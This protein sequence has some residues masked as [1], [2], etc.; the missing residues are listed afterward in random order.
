MK[1]EILIPL[2]IL[3]KA[4]EELEKELYS[5]NLKRQNKQIRL[6]LKTHKHQQ[7]IGNAYD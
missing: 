3:A 4:T 7:A 2:A 1:K 6:A 5:D